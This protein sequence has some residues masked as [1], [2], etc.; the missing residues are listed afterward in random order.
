[1]QWQGENSRH[2]L[3]LS[4]THGLVRKLGG[5]IY[6]SS[7]EGMGT[8]FTLVFPVNESANGAEAWRE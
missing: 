1:M 3:I 8:S 7:E 6:V 5:E 2:A 4:I